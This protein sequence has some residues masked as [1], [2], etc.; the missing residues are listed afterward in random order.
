[1]QKKD[2]WM[3]FYHAGRELLRY[4]LYGSF[5][6]ERE[7]TIELLAA[8]NGIPAGEIYTEIINRREK[9]HE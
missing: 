8:E 1:M 3:V 9:K 6:G 7:N 2:L 5:P 4:T